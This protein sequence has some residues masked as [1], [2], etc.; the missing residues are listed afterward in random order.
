MFIGINGDKDELKEAISEVVTT[1]KYKKTETPAQSEA[2]ATTAEKA[3][4]NN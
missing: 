2:A 1:Y 3:T 4:I